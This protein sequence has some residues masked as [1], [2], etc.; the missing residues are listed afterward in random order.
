MIIVITPENF[1]SNEAEIIN[2]LFNEG[3]DFLHIRKP[4]AVEEKVSDLI[5]KIDCQFH[6]RLVI[7]QHYH[8]SETFKISR[9]HI[10]ETD[11]KNELQSS[12]KN[13]IISTS[14]H[15]IEAFNEL[16]E[17]WEYAFFS[18]VFPSISKKGYGK[19]STVLDDIKKRTHSN[20]KLIALGGINENNIQ[21][22]NKEKVDG[23]ALLGTIWENKEPLK[24]F[25]KCRKIVLS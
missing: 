22:L 16:D 25:K 3:L 8:L 18:P 4:F 23:V 12:M 14:V 15:T 2:E 17:I 5:E 13:Q 19:N 6:S 20:V 24:I 11:R 7:H 10:K 9:F 1:L 21:I